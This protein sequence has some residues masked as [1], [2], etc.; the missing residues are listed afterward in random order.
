MFK[1]ITTYRLIAGVVSAFALL[2]V[3][4][5]WLVADDLLMESTYVVVVFPLL[6]FNLIRF[7]TNW[8][9]LNDWLVLLLDVG[10]IS[11]TGLNIYI[12][13]IL[14]FGFGYTGVPISLAWYLGFAATLALLVISITD[15]I[16]NKEKLSPYN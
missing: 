8:I 7:F 5:D 16:R 1:N 11:I 14:L 10:M 13:L 15:I 2:A 12:L 3:M 4:F 6:I 9:R